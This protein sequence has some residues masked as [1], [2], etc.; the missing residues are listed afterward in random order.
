ME[1]GHSILIHYNI[2]HKYNEMKSLIE[3]ASY[4]WYNINPF[5]YSQLG[6][7]QRDP[8]LFTLNF[9][10]GLN[11]FEGYLYEVDGDDHSDRTATHMSEGW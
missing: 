3:S 10:D 5:F 11:N 4:K 9:N 1:Q 8:R 2:L 7:S 6:Q